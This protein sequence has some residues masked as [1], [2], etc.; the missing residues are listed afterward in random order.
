M[1]YYRSLIQ[2]VVTPTYT[3]PWGICSHFWKFDNTFTD[4]VGS[5]NGTGGG[6][7]GYAT[8][9]INDCVSFDGINDSVDLGFSTFTNEVDQ[10]F[11]IVFQYY[12]SAGSGAHSPWSYWTNTGKGCIFYY[13]IVGGYPFQFYINGPSGNVGIPQIAILLNTNAWN[14][15]GVTYKKGVSVELYINGVISNTVLTT[16]TP[17]ITGSN[18]VNFGRISDGVPQA[19][20]DGKVDE[21]GFYQGLLTASDHS[22]LHN[23]GVG[24]TLN[25]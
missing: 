4:S 22:Y 16:M 25:G 5:F 20:D 24:K 2:S 1:S 18:Y 11:S 9:K 15:V 19:Y 17:T 10:D 23:G 13:D 7:V 14:T 6:G 3:F 21:F 8:G 12:Y